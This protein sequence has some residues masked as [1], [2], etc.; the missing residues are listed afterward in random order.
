MT[1]RG[2]VLWVWLLAMAAF[3]LA[4]VALPAGV[5]V[6]GRQGAGVWAV[7]DRLVMGPAPLAALV[8]VLA[9]LG[10]GTLA[11]LA[12]WRLERLDLWAGV[13][14]T[15]LLV[16][17][18][19]LGGSSEMGMR[20]ALHASIGLAIGALCGV[21]GL[22]GVDKG[23]LRVAASCGVSPARRFL[24]VLLPLAAPGVLAGLVLANVASVAVS[25]VSAA[26]TVSRPLR[27]VLDL[28][29]ASLGALVGAGLV[30][31]AAVAAALALLRRP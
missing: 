2:V 10:P 6:A 20:L 8:A 25:L 23:L 21:I 9:A 27:A 5:I 13:L 31:C 3:Q 29:P 17:A 7:L 19:L 15:P 1:V 26:M 16:P 11:A 14:V 30:P 18:A 22:G 28:P 12:L 24:R 4:V